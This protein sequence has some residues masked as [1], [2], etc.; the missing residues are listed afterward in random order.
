MQIVFIG[1]D[2]S[3]PKTLIVPILDFHPK[4][5][6]TDLVLST[7]INDVTQRLA[8]CYIYI[9]RT[10]SRSLIDKLQNTRSPLILIANENYRSQLFIPFD[11]LMPT[12][13]SAESLEI[14]TDNI[15]SLISL[16]EMEYQRNIDRQILSDEDE[17]DRLISERSEDSVP[18]TVHEPTPEQKLVALPYLEES[19]EEPFDSRDNAQ[20]NTG[21]TAKNS[22]LTDNEQKALD[23][24]R[25]RESPKI[26]ASRINV[27]LATYYR[28][29]SRARKLIM[30]LESSS[31]YSEESQNLGKKELT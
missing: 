17:W 20:E 8:H 18:P 23:S 31:L 5:Q 30:Q 24:W 28:I 14:I 22:I 25:E 2:E 7:Q 15:N 1:D 12:S 11:N 9:D 6:R 26:A 13:C 29:L 3:P 16:H 27:S 10:P 19:E 21:A 4:I